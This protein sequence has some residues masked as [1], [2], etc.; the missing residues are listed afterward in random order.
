MIPLFHVSLPPRDE[1]MPELERV[2]Y[3]GYIAQGKQV[4]QFEDMLKDFFGN[5]NVLTV[6]SGTAAIQLA[7]RLAGVEGGE[8]VTTPMT[9]AATALPILA[10]RAFPVWADVDPL[11]GNMDARSAEMAITP[12]TKAI[13]TMHWG[14]QPGDMSTLNGV[15]RNYNIP[16]IVDAAHALGATYG[17]DMVGAASTADFTCFSLQ[18]IKHITT[19]DGGIVTTRHAD[20]YK[21]GKILR[22]FGLDREAPAV[23][24]RTEVDIPEWG[25]KFHMNDIAATIGIAQMK[26]LPDIVDAHRDNARFYDEVLGVRRQHVSRHATG[27]WWLYTLLLDNASQ[28]NRFMEHMKA[29]G[30]Q[31]SRVHSRLDGLTCFDSFSG[32]DLPG[33]TWFYDREVAIPVHA[34]LS[35]ID[36]MDV[37]KAVRDFFRYYA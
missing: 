4:D 7:L 29:R 36:R 12:K 8:V 34:G 3:S 16:L 37:A 23:D 11:S 15:A 6:S 2:L 10:E 35:V 20:A 24:A 19:G 28:R 21:R 18:A 31:V 13:L 9:C 32:D 17:K 25:Y 30:I 26:G 14:G 33:V 22:W 5:P 1:L 27:A